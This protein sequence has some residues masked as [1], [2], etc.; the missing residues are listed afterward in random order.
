MIEIGRKIST[1]RRFRI[2]V[3]GLALGM[4]VLVGAIIGSLSWACVPAIAFA[5][6]VT[7]C[8]YRYASSL[9]SSPD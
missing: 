5:T 8:R 9:S 6:V 3:G 7:I 2:A 1:D 4:A